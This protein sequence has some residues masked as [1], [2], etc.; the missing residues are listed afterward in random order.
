MSSSLSSQHRAGWDG[1]CSIRWKGGK[2]YKKKRT[3]IDKQ[4]KIYVQIQEAIQVKSNEALINE[5]EGGRGAVEKE[6]S[7]DWDDRGRL[8]ERVTVEVKSR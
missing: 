2:Q 5:R 8:G 4:V 7:G 6:S 1:C 3:E